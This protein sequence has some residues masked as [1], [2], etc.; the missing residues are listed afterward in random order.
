MI[1]FDTKGTS[2]NGQQLWSNASATSGTYNFYI[3]GAQ[4]AKITDNW[5]NP[6]VS[7][8][9]P[10]TA[11]PVLSGGALAG[12]P[13]NIA[14]IGAESSLYPTSATG[15]TLM[16][17]AQ[18]STG[19]HHFTNNGGYTHVTITS[20]DG[21]N[22]NG[23][24]EFC[25]TN[26]L[27]M[28][29]SYRGTG[30]DCLIFTNKDSVESIDIGLKFYN[31]S[32]LGKITFLTDNTATSLLQLQAPVT[33]C[34]EGIVIR[35]A[36][37]GASTGPIITAGVFNG[38]SPQD[39]AIPVT[40]QAVGSA[41]VFL[42]SASA[43]A[44]AAKWSNGT[45]TPVNYITSY[46]V[47]TAF[48]PA[49]TN[50]DSSDANCPFLYVSKA[51]GPH[52]FQTQGSANTAT[53]GRTQFSVTH[54][55]NAISNLQVTGGTS[56]ARPAMSV[57]STSETDVPMVLAP[58]GS[59]NVQIGSTAGQGLIVGVSALATTSTNGFIWIP[60]CPGSAGGAATAPYTNAA[61]MVYDS[62]NNFIW[63][64]CGGTWRHTSALV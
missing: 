52:V 45:G 53:G 12:G 23:E 8:Q 26:K 34:T 56:A 46:S 19:Y 2:T 60:S 54:T 4:N 31:S 20:P 28:C 16:F 21:T 40:I 32:H 35:A 14:V 3:N 44:F 50:V 49:I 27:L 62:T 17:V 24:N 25:Y 6:N 9:G 13:D 36:L 58:Q 33:A 1:N 39:T 18:G 57:A 47:G 51:A 63:V 30:R 10:V 29:G 38:F 22:P 37:S 7:Y 59:A 64:R 55:A 42:Q 41:P 61:A 15:A 43:P 5:W 48:W 11:W